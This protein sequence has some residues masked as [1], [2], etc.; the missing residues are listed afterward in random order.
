M[1]PDTVAFLD[2]DTLAR[3]RADFPLINGSDTLYLDNA[4]TS[5]KP[6]QVISTLADFYRQH[7]ANVHRAN[8]PLGERATQLFEHA[9]QAVSGFI[10]AASAEQ[11]IWT[12]GATEAINLVANSFGADLKPGDEIL[13]STLE[14]H[15]NIVPWQMLCERSGARLVP[16]P[17]Q[18]DLNI[19]MAAFRRLL[20]K[21]TRLLAITQASNAL[22]VCPEIHRLTEEAQAVGAR[23]LIDGAQAVAHAAIDV[24]ALG[25]D[26][27]VFSGHKMYGPSGIG[28][29]Y[30]KAEL[31]ADMT[32]WQ[33]G[34]EMIEQ[35]SFSGSRY[36]RAPFR[37][38]AGTP[39]IAAAVGLAA[40][41]DYLSTL[42]ANAILAHERALQQ[43]LWQGLE[44]LPEFHCLNRPGG[45]PLIS[46]VHESLHTYD[47]GHWLG[48]QGIAI[49]TG[50]HCAMPLMEAL[51]QP[52]G[53]ARASF[54]LYNSPGEVDTLLESL[55]ALQ[56]S[57]QPRVQVAE[58]IADSSSPSAADTALAG[59]G[60][61]PSQSLQTSHSGSL[62][63]HIAHAKS[64]QQRYAVLIKAAKARPPLAEHHR[65][66]TYRLHG[67]TSK[68]WLHHHYDEQTQQLSFFYD[69]DAR[70]MLG[71]GLLLLEAIEGKTPL[72]IQTFDFASYLQ[73]LS[74]TQQLSA[75]RNNG[76]QT[77]VAEIQ[78]I[79]GL[80]Q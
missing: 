72:Q 66:D 49:R 35:V 70:I 1:T 13:V 50:H 76:L 63:Q 5:Q 11:I 2:N 18:A 56:T 58:R 45:V 24:Q 14:H 15:A 36:Q 44:Q 42:D 19:D 43:R 31:L 74:I 48:Q 22:G 71:L 3:I 38:E 46:F 69:S 4:A 17:L 55:A 41:I 33:G 51:Q 16:I 23:V 27:Y 80:Y 21:R 61:T 34:G 40:A 53:T 67:C 30:G 75:S 12:K 62:S 26:F 28:V 65:A 20:N 64:W 6:E 47:I 52:A 79:A 77:L 7:N 37:F 9:R 54:A 8:H 29:L 78:R 32:A 59:A 73:S 39:P 60:A 68:V 10:N 57:L 25:C